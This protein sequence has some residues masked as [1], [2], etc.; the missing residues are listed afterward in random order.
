MSSG[1]FSRP[2]HVWEKHAGIHTIYE[3]YCYFSDTPIKIFMADF[4]KNIIQTDSINQYNMECE[5]AHRFTS[6]SSVI[7][8]CAE[9]NAPLPHSTVSFTVPG[10][11]AET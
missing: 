7:A 11:S 2:S 8:H 10:L 9:Y 3:N 5:H 1:H 6:D 4:L